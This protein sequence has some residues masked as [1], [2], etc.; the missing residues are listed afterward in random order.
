MTDDPDAPYVAGL[1]MGCIMQ[2]QESKPA[3]DPIPDMIMRGID[4]A[5]DGPDTDEFVKCWFYVE[6]GRLR[7]K[8]RVTIEYVGGE[9]T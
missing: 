4:E 8:Y 5:V 3:G 9:E 6:V 2:R 7:L 1:I